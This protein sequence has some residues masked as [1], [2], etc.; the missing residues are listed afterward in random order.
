[1]AHLVEGLDKLI[2]QVRCKNDQMQWKLRRDMQVC[3]GEF[4]NGGGK[5]K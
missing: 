3:E 1:V 2:V 5:K 4:S